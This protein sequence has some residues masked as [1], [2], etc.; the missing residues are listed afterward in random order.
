MT[1][2][3]AAAAAL[4][5]AENVLS[6]RPRLRDATGFDVATELTCIL[7]DMAAGRIRCTKKTAALAREELAIRASDPSRCGPF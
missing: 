2:A 7:E 1:K 3:A 5:S 6:F 4:L